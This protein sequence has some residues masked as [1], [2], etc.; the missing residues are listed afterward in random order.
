MILCEPF[1]GSAAVTYHLLGSKPPISYQG[2]KAGYAAVIAAILGLRRPSGIVLGEV[3]PWAAVHATLG[4]ASGSAVEVAAHIMTRAWVHP[5]GENFAPTKSVNRT[6]YASDGSQHVFVA[7]TPQT[8]SNTV[9]ALPHP[10]AAE[11]AAV[12]RSWAGEEPR[13][14]WDRLKAEG[15]PSL[16]PVEGGRWL[17]PCEVGEV[18]SAI[19]THR[20]SFS[21]KGVEH[22]YGGPGC[23]VK[24]NRA[25]WTTAARDEALSPERTAA[26]IGSLGDGFPS[27]AVWQGTAET[28][29][30]PDDLTGW[31]IFADPPY[32]GTSGYPHG[33]CPRAT[34]LRLA[35][36]WGER[37][38]VV[39]I[40]EACP[41]NGALGAG[42]QAVE[43]G[44]ERKGAKRTF[45]RQ[46]SEWLTLNR[47]PLYRPHRGQV[48]MFGGGL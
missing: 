33:D 14:L 30:L 21:G 27:L 40:S 34:V 46:Q 43:I 45:S 31:V 28:L 25:A 22:G 36:E 8:Q 41:L 4:G 24:T 19:L 3:G 13:A 38:A 29:A 2:S 35:R 12:I 15:W 42:W 48:G 1:A 16:L 18:A 44:H 23:E 32:Q 20:W 7:V 10:R 5:S 39:A 6:V 37:G 47:E 17:G 9:A 11:V 26:T